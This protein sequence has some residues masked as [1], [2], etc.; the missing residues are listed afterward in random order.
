MKKEILKDKNYTHLDIRKH[1][2]DYETRIKNI[3]WVSHHGFYPFIHFEVNLD[4]YVD[5]DNGKHI[6]SKTREIYYS[7]HVDRYIYEYYGSQLNT[8]YNRFVNSTG[9]GKVSI[10]YRNNTP[11]KC[12]IH[13]AKDAFE[14]ICSCK[15]AYVFVGDFSNFFDKLDHKYLKETLKTVLDKKELNQAEYAIYKNITHFTYVEAKDIEIF[16]GKTRVEMRNLDKYFDTQEFQV[17]KKTHL[18]K[19]ENDYGIPQGSSISSVYANVYMIHFDK[20]MNDLATSNGGLYR[21]YCDDIIFV[22]PCTN[23]DIQNKTYNEI[24][25]RIFAIKDRIKNLELNEDKTE[26]FYYNDGS[27]IKLAGDGSAINYLGFT[28]DGKEVRIREKSLFKYYNRAY[29]KIRRVNAS[30]TEGGYIAGKKAVYK[31]YT[32]LGNTK[33]KKT[34]GNFLTYAYKAQRIFDESDCLVCGIKKQV[35]GH[36]N[37]INNRLCWDPDLGE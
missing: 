23:D 24:T 37:K 25:E 15:S 4:K 17:F 19:N 20:M 14:F 22:I 8:A 10:A 36:W 16:K 13:F 28:F 6:K 33:S 27:L 34:Y 30:K 29:K 1:H 32:H 18:K 31:S 11:G 2:Q 7:A 12:N 21:R 3:K 26:Q 35:K 5:S 9:I